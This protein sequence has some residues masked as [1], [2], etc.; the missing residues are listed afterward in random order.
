M[1]EGNS[2]PHMRGVMLGENTGYLALTGFDADADGQFGEALS[3]LR[4]RGD[5]ETTVGR[6]ATGA[7]APVAPDQKST[8]TLIR[9][10]RAG[11]MVVGVSHEPPGMNP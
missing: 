3:E 2:T 7:V 6:L 1:R 11:T 8:C 4:G 5:P 10:Y 9:A